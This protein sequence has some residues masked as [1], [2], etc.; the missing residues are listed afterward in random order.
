MTDSHKMSD[1]NLIGNSDM[2]GDSCL[3]VAAPVCKALS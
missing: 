1:S 3:T 2:L